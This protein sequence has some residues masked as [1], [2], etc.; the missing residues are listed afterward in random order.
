[1]RSSDPIYRMGVRRMCAPTRAIHVGGRS[2]ATVAVSDSLGEADGPGGDFS[3]S[4]KTV[5]GVRVLCERVIYF[6][7]RFLP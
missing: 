7:H 6:N 2:R 4:V 1:M 5:G 3:C